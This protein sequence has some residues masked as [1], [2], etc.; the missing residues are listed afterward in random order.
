[1]ARD[2][3]ILRESSPHRRF[4][5]LGLGALPF[6]FVPLAGLQRIYVGRIKT[7]IL[8]L[9]TFGLLG[10]GQLIDM[11]MIALGQFRDGRGRRVLAWATGAADHLSKPVNEYS[12]VLRETWSASRVGYRLGN[13]FLNLVGALLLVTTLMAGIALVIRFP[14]AIGAGVVPNIGLEIERELGMRDW[15]LLANN[16]IAFFV[17]VL[18]ALTATVLLL[19]RR[20]SG[21]WHMLR[22]PLA[23]VGFMAA[24]HFIGMAFS[25]GQQW[26]TVGMLVQDR[27]IGQAMLTAFRRAPFGSVWPPL[28]FGCVLLVAAIF[29]LA[30]PADRPA[31]KESAGK[32]TTSRDALA[33]ASAHGA[34]ID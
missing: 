8:W 33:A 24:V 16:I 15:P 11:V 23:G 21:I 20:Q 5:A 17:V 14:D 19:A 3:D 13:L 30:W 34:R 18:S 27:L 25:F 32:L 9:L 12:A 28:I 7:G 29:V 6:L 26:Q 31:G 1:M 10:I 4:V 22:V 2:A